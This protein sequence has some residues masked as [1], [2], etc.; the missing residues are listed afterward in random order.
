MVRRGGRRWSPAYLETEGVH[1]HLVDGGDV[2]VQRQEPRAL[3]PGHQ[4]EQLLR[5]P[6]REHFE[7]CVAVHH[8]HLD[9][10]GG[11]FVVFDLLG[12][13][14]DTIMVNYATTVS[15]GGAATG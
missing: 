9:V 8:R 14:E 1:G 13:S 11:C 12:V 5:P 3:Q 4:L 2:E 10:C 7:V 15:G 6:P